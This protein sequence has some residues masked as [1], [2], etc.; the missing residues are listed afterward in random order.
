MLRNSILARLVLW[1]TCH[2]VMQHEQFHSAPG[3]AVGTPAYLA[4]EVIQATQD[5]TYDAKVYGV[6]SL[7]T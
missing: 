5:A 4:P 2:D 1:I 6:T 7:Q 3:S